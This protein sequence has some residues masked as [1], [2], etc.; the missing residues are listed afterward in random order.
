MQVRL[1]PEVAEALER[2]AKDEA[3]SVAKLV[4][5]T[6]RRS[7]PAPDDEPAPAQSLT[8][9]TRNNARVSVAGARHRPR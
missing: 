1:D 8:G 9:Q 4:N 6:L 3:T 7:L 5:R 2:V